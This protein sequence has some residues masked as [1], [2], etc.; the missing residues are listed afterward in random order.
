MVDLDGFKA[1]NDAH[2]HMAGDDALRVVGRRLVG[3]VRERDVVARIGGD[4]FVLVLPDLHPG[5]G[6]AEECARRVRAALAGPIELDHASP[7]LGAATG[8]ACF[9]RDGADGVALLAHADRA[10]YRAKR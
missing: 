6:T 4:E 10:M 1:L 2:G 7:R 5:Q 8:V 9:P 3:C